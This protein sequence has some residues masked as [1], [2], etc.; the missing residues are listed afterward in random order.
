MP[1]LFVDCD[2]TL[3]LWEAEHLNQDR[4]LW[5]RDKYELNM[6]LIGD[7]NCFLQHHED[8]QLVVWS[9]GGVDYASIWA[10]RCH[11]SPRAVILPKDMRTPTDQDICVDDMYGELTPRDKRVR[12]I[13]PRDFGRCPICLS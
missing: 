3:V 5:V 1:R 8:Y 6:A 12:V 13:H 9:G 10:A 11:F 4:T 2:D 7:I